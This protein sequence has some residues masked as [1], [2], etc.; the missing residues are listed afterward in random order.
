MPAP[1]GDGGRRWGRAGSSM[2]ETGRGVEI[3]NLSFRGREHREKTASSQKGRGSP[4]FPFERTPLPAAQP[5]EG[6]P[7]NRHFRRPTPALLLTLAACQSGASEEPAVQPSS[8]QG[9]RGPAGPEGAPTVRRGLGGAAGRAGCRGCSGAR[10]CHRDRARQGCPARRA[11][12]GPIGP[13]VRAGL[14]G[15]RAPGRPPGPRSRRPRRPSSA[16]PTSWTCPAWASASRQSRHADARV[17]TAAGE[18]GRPGG[19]PV[20]CGLWLGGEAPHVLEQVTLMAPANG[21]PSSPS[22]LGDARP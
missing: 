5:I 7:M 3:G 11:A 14:R 16:R 2:D 22:L 12:E 6:T 21:R 10:G 18:R 1:G 15:R 13:R 20:T 9:E 19:G 17:I 4:V 8:A